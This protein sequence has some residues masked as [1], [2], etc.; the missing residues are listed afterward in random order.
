MHTNYA[1]GS[2]L[3]QGVPRATGWSARQAR[4]PPE[5]PARHP[6]P[7][8]RAQFCSKALGGGSVD[9]HTLDSQPRILR[10]PLREVV[11]P[12]YERVV[13]GEGKPGFAMFR[14]R[15]PQSWVSA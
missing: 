1:C 5:R 4:A 14:A 13:A 12:G 15:L 11:R 9:V 10:V 3:K 6:S 8:H 7:P 2:S